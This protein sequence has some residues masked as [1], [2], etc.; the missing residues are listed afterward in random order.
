MSKDQQ[1]SE[2]IQPGA[3]KLSAEKVA[4]IRKVF[5]E[6][7]GYV[8]GTARRTGFAKSTVSRYARKR[9]WHKELLCSDPNQP[10]RQI[11]MRNT[12]SR[13]PASDKN[14]EKIVSVED[15]ENGDAK[16]QIMSKLIA[17]RKLLFDEIIRDE[18]PQ[19]TDSPPLKILPKTL[20]E[21]VKALI[22]IDKRITER[23]GNQP[24]TVLDTYQNILA[25]CARIMEDKSE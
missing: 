17:L 10:N 12:A 18:K 14:N 22:D 9:G 23:E 20:A 3:G 6:T 8:S 25:R 5:M 2:E 21:A 19:V 4:E 24:T 16:E 15:K 13:S 7:G 1:R 11:E